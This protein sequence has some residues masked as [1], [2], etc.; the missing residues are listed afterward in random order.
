[1][2]NVYHHLEKPVELL[3]NL[4]PS[5]K[6]DGILVIV[7]RIPEKSRWASEA[8][9]KDRLIRQAEEAGYILE[10][11]EKFLAEDNIYF[12]KKKGKNNKIEAVPGCSLMNT[13]CYPNEHLF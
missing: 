4:I 6:N 13:W 3:K 11:I 8:T 1:M 9:P 5:L 10:K 2:I 7:E 12:F